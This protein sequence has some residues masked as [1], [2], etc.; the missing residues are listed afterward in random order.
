MTRKGLPTSRRV[1]L[2]L[3]GVAGMAAASLGLPAR[4]ARVA[5]KARIV[6]IG[7]GSAGTALVNRLVERLDG[8][9]ITIIDA[10][11]SICINRAF[12]W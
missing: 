2:G 12:R 10:V 8:T 5:T 9:Q 7:A 4:A 6:I 11:L 3:V 1:F